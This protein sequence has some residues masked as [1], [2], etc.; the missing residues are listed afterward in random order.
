MNHGFHKNLMMNNA[1]SNY[2]LSTLDYSLVWIMSTMQRQPSAMSNRQEHR[3][4][5]CDGRTH[6]IIYFFHCPCSGELSYLWQPPEAFDFR[7][8]S[9]QASFLFWPKQCSMLYDVI[10]TPISFRCITS[11]RNLYIYITYMIEIYLIINQSCSLLFSNSTTRWSDQRELKVHHVRNIW[12]IQ[13]TSLDK[14]GMSHKE[15]KQQKDLRSIW[16]VL[17][18]LHIFKFGKTT[19]C[20]GS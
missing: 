4:F 10:C 15:Q 9:H 5:D 6:K 18:S 17:V 1:D 3:I 12:D 13:T 19:G 7:L 14:G 2:A 20:L 11:K 16:G 8:H